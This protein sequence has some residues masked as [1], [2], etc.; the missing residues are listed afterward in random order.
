MSKATVRKSKVFSFPSG[1]AATAQVLPP[2]PKT[3]SKRKKSLVERAREA[4]TDPALVSLEV[5]EH[6]AAYLVGALMDAQRA[7]ET[8]E[9]QWKEAGNMQQ[10]AIFAAKARACGALAVRVAKAMTGAK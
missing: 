9:R 6:E 3:Q 10:S 2:P 4:A 7:A 1:R 5:F 8:S